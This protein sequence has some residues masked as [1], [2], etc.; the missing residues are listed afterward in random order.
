MLASSGSAH[1]RDTKGLATPTRQR[2]SPS[3]VNDSDSDDDVP[4]QQLRTQPSFQTPQRPQGIARRDGLADQGIPASAPG[5][6]PG[7]ASLRNTS[8][9]TP[10]RAPPLSA[11]AAAAR[12]RAAAYFRDAGDREL[13]AGE[14]Y[15][16][17]AEN[18]LR[19][20]ELWELAE[21]E[22]A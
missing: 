11:N 21:R 3:A 1:E 14:N 4:P 6:L 20:A 13:K 9:Q 16:M 7:R 2:G 22:G 5:R 10:S 19:A 12:N 17:A 8:P 18:E 15:R